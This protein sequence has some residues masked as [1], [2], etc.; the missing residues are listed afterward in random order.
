MLGPVAAPKEEDLYRVFH[1]SCATEHDIY[2]SS[3]I[4]VG[5]VE[6]RFSWLESDVLGPL[7]LTRLYEQYFHRRTLGH[8]EKRVHT[9]YGCVTEFVTVAS[10]PF[11]TTLCR[12]DYRE[13]S[14]LSDLLFTAA[15][16]GE[17]RQGLLITVQ[18]VGVRHTEGVAFIRPLLDRVRG[19]STL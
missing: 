6:Y 3:A 8:T 11:K 7:R 1:S 16:V 17:P 5:R 12:R 4:Q 9:R 19:E 14:E 10:K 18:Q 2:L 13:Y 15:L